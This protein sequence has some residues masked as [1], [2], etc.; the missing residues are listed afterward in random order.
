M[1]ALARNMDMEAAEAAKR[2]RLVDEDNA[3][4]LSRRKLQKQVH[5]ATAKLR[6]TKQSIVYA[7]SVLEAKRAA[8][9]FTVDNL[10]GSGRRCGHAKKQLLELLDRL[11]RIG[12]G[13]SAPRRNDFAW[14]KN[15]WDASMSEEHGDAWPR[16]L[17]G[18]VQNILNDFEGGASN[19][20]SVFVRA[21]TVR[22][23]S[24]SL[25]LCVPGAS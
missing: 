16:V 14:F 7:E 13:L 21:E 2:K 9:T 22:N 3:R 23:F 18:W 24:E 6:A 4:T 8:R 17:G 15:A 20:F 1:R 10:G 12:Q 5:D 19:E 25:A 11:A